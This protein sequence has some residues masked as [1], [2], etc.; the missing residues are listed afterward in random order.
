MDGMPGSVE[1]RS[2]ADTAG[3]HVTVHFELAQ[4]SAGYPPVA[5]EALW[6]VRVG[7]AQFRLDNI[8]YFVCGVSCFDIIE[9]QEDTSG[10]FKYLRLVEPS[11]HSTLRVTLHDK[12]GDRRSLKERV[13]EL[14]NQLHA[15]G[16]SSE[17]SHIAGLISVDVPPDAVLADVRLVLDGGMTRGEWDY[18]KATLRESV[19]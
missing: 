15:L 12:G 2:R 5:S 3:N 8:P 19:H 7:P 16:C 18:E 9:A 4:D 17:I 13:H 1:D 6:A 14:R 10:Y 11:G